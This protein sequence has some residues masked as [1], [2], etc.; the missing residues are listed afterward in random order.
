MFVRLFFIN[1]FE[2]PLGVESTQDQ[3]QGACSAAAHHFQPRIAMVR[4]SLEPCL[5]KHHQKVES[6]AKISRNYFLG[7][8]LVGGSTGSAA[9]PRFL[10]SE[11]LGSSFAFGFAFGSGLDLALLAGLMF[12]S[13]NRLVEVLVASWN[14]IQFVVA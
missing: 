2:F 5:P 10:E 12:L 14:Q 8:F 6:P 3:I 4:S 13:L 11:P 7:F 9:F 1:C